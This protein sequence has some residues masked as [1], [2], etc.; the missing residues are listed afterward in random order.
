MRSYFLN[1]ADNVLSKLKDLY[2]SININM[3]QASHA[4]YR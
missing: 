4:S 1:D 3:I 2:A